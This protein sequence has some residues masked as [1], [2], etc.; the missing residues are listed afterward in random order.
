MAGFQPG[1]LAFAAMLLVLIGVAPYVG[2]FGEAV[3]GWLHRRKR[4]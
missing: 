3:G 4:P 2:P 1:E